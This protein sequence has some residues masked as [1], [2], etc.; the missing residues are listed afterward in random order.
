MGFTGRDKGYEKTPTHSVEA[1]ILGDPKEEVR[2]G[3]ETFLAY[4]TP[5]G[6]MAVKVDGEMES[7]DDLSA[8]DLEAV[9]TEYQTVLMEA[10]SRTTS[11]S[12]TGMEDVLY[13]AGIE[14]A[15]CRFPQ[16]IR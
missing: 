12:E 6:D 1:E 9:P 14:E 15:R 16:R 4:E 11:D 10:F 2:I 7:Y 5:Y 13:E 8:E 3:E